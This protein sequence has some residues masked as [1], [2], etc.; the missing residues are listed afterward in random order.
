MG[1]YILYI[2]ILASCHSCF[3]LIL[4]FHLS[5][6]VNFSLT[7]ISCLLRSFYVF[8]YFF[9][10]ISCR[11][12]F[13]WNHL[14]FFFLG[15]NLFLSNLF[16]F[17]GHGI[18][19]EINFVSSSSKYSQEWS[20]FLYRIQFLVLYTLIQKLFASHCFLFSTHLLT[21]VIGSF[22]FLSSVLL[23]ASSISRSILLVSLLFHFALL[24][25]FP[26]KIY[27]LLH[28]HVR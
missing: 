14:Y 26:V 23:H 3:L 22:L 28:S 4:I 19:V 8:R 24:L 12:V 13:L 9:C 2:L 1:M 5:R 27:N 20:V 16:L 7:S 25:S 17:F 11:M 18:S 21:G 6:L 10:S 15:K